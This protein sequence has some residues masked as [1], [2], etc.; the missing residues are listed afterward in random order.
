M[1]GFPREADTSR[2]GRYMR[3][4]R[5]L[6]QVGGI[7]FGGSG[8]RFRFAGHAGPP[9]RPAP[10]PSPPR[11]RLPDGFAVE[12]AATTH[13]SRDGH[14]MLGGSPPRLLRLGAAAVRLLEDGGFVVT[15]AASAALARRLLDAGL[16][17]PRPPIPPVH[18][19]TVAI[20]IRD[21]ADQLDALLTAL[22]A[23]PPTSPLPVLVVD[24]GSQD[25]DALARVARRHG[26]RLLAHPR[27]LGPAAARNTALREAETAYVAFCDS[28]VIPEPGWLAGLLAHFDD[29][30]VA[31][32][33]PRIVALSPAVPRP[34]DRYEQ[35]RSP[36]D[37]GSRE[38]PVVPVSMLSYVPSATIVVRRSAVGAGFA[39]GMRVGEDVDLCMRLHEAGWRLRYVPSVR[40]AHRHRTDL[41]RW[42][43]QRAGY[44]TGAADLSLRHPGRVPPLYAAPWSLAACALL[45]RGRPAPAV[46]ALA[47]TAMT[48]VKVARRMPD[49]DHPQR[50][51]TLL[52][53]AALRGTAEQLLRCATRHHWPIAVAAAAVSRRA[54]YT[55]ATAA[56]AEG[57]VDHYRSRTPL[58]PL[59]YTAIRRLDDL[60]YGWG[61]WQGALR[62]RTAAPLLPRLA[63]P[64]RG[65]AGK[66]PWEPR[67]L[68][69]TSHQP[70]T[71]TVETW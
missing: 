14:L 5:V 28:D 50:A 15:D 2:S 60:A 27:N 47:L 42:L 61:V 12:L 40:V 20:P 66:R 31:L 58:D 36:L 33:A 38:G 41:R 23:D 52:S 55:L 70:A 45:L 8:G 67:P 51:G 7:L 43:A 10:L 9:P 46:T 48:A 65:G 35:V 3:S 21:R 53:L 71:A 26:A 22:R 62:R 64:V 68:T 44:G 29:P 19:T 54:R 25:P 16:A 30:A 56:L 59:T 4:F 49:A 18:D 37:M 63:L 69:P 34:L 6:P 11:D 1:T 24:D 32:V 39:P 17:H 13:R 57:L